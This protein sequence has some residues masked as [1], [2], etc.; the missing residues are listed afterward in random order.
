MYIYVEIYASCNMRL[1][2]KLFII[3]INETQIGKKNK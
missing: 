1:N 3:I 2:I